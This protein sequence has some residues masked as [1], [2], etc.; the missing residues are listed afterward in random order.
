VKTAT[1]ATRRKGV[2]S[3]VSGSEAM[4]KAQ[5][6]KLELDNSDLMDLP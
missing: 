3:M 4:M 2:E 1:S 5:S 6:R